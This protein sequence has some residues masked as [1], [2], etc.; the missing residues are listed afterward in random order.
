M[1]RIANDDAGAAVTPREAE[2]GTLVA[3]GL[4]TLDGEQ[5]LRDAEGVGKRNPDTAGAY[6][7]AEPGLQLT[8]KWHR[9]HA[10]MI[11]SEAVSGDYNRRCFD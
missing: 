9:R 2:D 5:G 4:R 10:M 1:Q 11:A 3:S 6:V 7:E 8:G